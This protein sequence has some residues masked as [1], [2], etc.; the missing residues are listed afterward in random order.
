MNTKTHSDTKRN[1]LH[2]GKEL[3]ENTRIVP[4]SVTAASALRSSKR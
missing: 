2:H 3:A 1:Q 4:F